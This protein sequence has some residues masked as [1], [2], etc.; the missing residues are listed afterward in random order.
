[1][2]LQTY[3]LP[4]SLEQEIN[5]LEERI[6]RFKRGELSA[7]ELKVRRVPFGVYEQRKKDTYMVRIRCAGACVK[8]EQLE[9]IAELSKTYGTEWIHLTSRQEIQLH[10]VLLENIVPVIRELKKV[11]L[12]SRGGGGNTIRNIMA[13]DDAGISND[14]AF[15]VTP[16]AIA[17]TSRM[18]AEPDSWNL[19]RKF[20]VNFSGSADD[21]G[22]A[23]IADVGFIARLKD[24]QKGFKVYVAGG[25]G[26]K[27]QVSNLLFD[28]V[29]DAE[30]YNV[31]RAVR[32]VF[33]KYG[34]RKNKH[35]ARLRFLW[36]TLGEEEFKRRFH[37]EYAAVQKENC[38][39]LQI[40]DIENAGGDPQTPVEGAEDKKD[41]ELW[42]KR[43]VRSQKQEGLFA[44]VLPIHLGHVPN[45]SVMQ[46]ARFL[47]PFGDN[48]IRMTMDQNFLIRNIPGKFLPNFY[49]FLKKTFDNF[50]RPYI[51]DKM[52]S[53]AG[54]STCQL[55]ICLSPGA[56]T[57]TKRA[58]EKCGLDLDALSDVKINISGC[59]NSCGQHHM[60]DLGFFGKVV[61]KDDKVYPAYNVVAGAVVG[62]GKT[63]LAEK[64][65]EVAARDI[66]KLVT[67]LF[68]LY[69][70]KKDGYKNFQEY[71]QTEG[72][73]DL[74]G[75]CEKYKEIPDFEDDKNY[76]FDWDTDQLFSVA[77]RG[78]GECSAG[79]FDLIENDF[80][81][82]Q[83]A[84]KLMEELAAS[85]G[86]L[87]QKGR[88]L[89]DI[90]FYCSRL[91]LVARA[92]EPKSETETYNYFRE[93]FINTGLVDIAFNELLTIAESGDT[94]GLLEREAQVYALV[95]RMRLLYDVMDS[96]FQFKLPEGE[97][98]A[99]LKKVAMTAP[100]EASFSAHTCAAA[101]PASPSAGG[102]AV[103]SPH[104]ADSPVLRANVVKDLRGVACPMNFVKTKMELARMK[105]KE[106]L[107]VWLDDGPPIE[108]VPG[109]VR[110]EG[111]TILQQK[112][113][114]GYWSVL[115]EKR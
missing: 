30:V 18:I 23:T 68:R 70:S 1:M 42:K 22:Y 62:D 71:I 85:G 43:F 8:P 37:E 21:R 32:T 89:K 44:F 101:G 60:A 51:I 95:D 54:A 49:N 100:S 52:L 102:P 46:L 91:L 55:G 67:D 93:Y 53:C 92:A 28:F 69:L 76:Y 58:L 115:I 14:E 7:T 114:N 113:I 88:H 77:E 50:N 112:R 104:E 15:D 97:V 61:R 103:C 36:Q 64:V 99:P 47:K 48:V 9:R 87:S 17:L 38:P 110:E 63:R 31:T 11:G 109:S 105:P 73:E 3:T 19:P 79:L 16:Y 94:S 12:T 75:I 26:A 80:G 25:L 72:K 83:Q 10:Y 13:Q 82:I 5:D 24:G 96:A 106:L 6:A 111:H 56:T 41:F 39:P 29:P 90:V 66:P 86:S 84:R 35:A 34:N 108:N 20:K 45:D 33:F 59:P 2:S 27:S 98:K 81:N 65:G 57:A 40:R 74:K 4:D 107:E 78:K